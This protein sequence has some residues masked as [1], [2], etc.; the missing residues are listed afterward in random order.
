[1]PDSRVRDAWGPSSYRRSALVVWTLLFGQISFEL[2]GRF[3]GVVGDTEALFDHTVGVM[4]SL[5]GLSQ[6][7]VS[8]CG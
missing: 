8:P 5:L 3:E 6:R 4:A 1:M 7:A 2:F